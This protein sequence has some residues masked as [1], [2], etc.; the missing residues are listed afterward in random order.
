MRKASDTGLVG[1]I[2]ALETRLLKSGDWIWGE[3]SETVERNLE[4]FYLFEER[5]KNMK[6]KNNSVRNTVGVLDVLKG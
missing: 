5:E 2:P 1:P 3:L 6:R 4:G